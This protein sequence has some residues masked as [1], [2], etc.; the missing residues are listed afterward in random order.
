[1]TNTPEFEIEV[2]RKV[3]DNE[4]GSHIKVGP[5]LD[6]LGLVEID[7]GKDY[8]RIVVPPKHA[9]WLAKAITATAEEM[10]G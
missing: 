3:F 8:G 1:V 7:G 5:D 4:H 6:G 9:I 10:M 2:V